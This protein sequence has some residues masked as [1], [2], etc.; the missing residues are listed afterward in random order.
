MRVAKGLDF[1]SRSF[2]AA[3]ILTVLAIASWRSALRLSLLNTLTIAGN[4]GLMLILVDTLRKIVGI[5]SR[6]G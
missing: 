4:F 2:V 6:A 3:L 1:R 5:M